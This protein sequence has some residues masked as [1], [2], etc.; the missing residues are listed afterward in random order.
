MDQAQTLRDMA[1]KKTVSG[2]PKGMKSKKA[3]NRPVRFI[4]V[5]SGKGGVGKTNVVANMA[6]ALAKQNKKILIFDADTGL[7]NVDILLGLAPK[8]NLNHVLK[9]E[10]DIKEVII[11]YKEGIHILP[12][13]SGIQQLSELNKDQRLIISEEFDSLIGQYDIVLLDTGAGISSNVTFFCASAHDI[14]VVVSPEPTSLTDAYALIKVLFQNHNQKKF[15][16]LIN[17][18][19]SDKEAKEVYKQLSSVLHRFLPLIS[20]DYM[21]YV[22]YD[23]NMIK[24]VRMQKPIID[25]YP[26]SKASRGL[27]ELAEKILEQEPALSLTENKVSFL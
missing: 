15:K 1:N 24:S 13:A 8:Y 21:G 25:C 2:K 19:K 14:L 27:S 22:L 10:K 5:T 4:A 18:A 9:R 23:E 6:C 12:A 20:V 26:Y 16:L 7:G 3:N 11:T 17:S